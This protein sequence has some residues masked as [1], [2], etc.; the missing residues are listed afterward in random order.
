MSLPNRLTELWTL[1]EAIARETGGEPSGVFDVCGLLLERRPRVWDYFCSPQNAVTFASTGGDGV[2]FGLMQL[3][4]LAPDKLPVVM[5]V[6]MSDAHNIVVAESFE[7]FLGL[8]YRLGWFFLEQL[9]YDP[10]GT[11]T[12]F[13]GADPDSEECEALLERIRLSLGL[14]HVPLTAERIQHLQARY[15]PLLEVPDPR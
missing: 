6:P 15:A 12:Y 5:T 8:G 1:A 14:W 2:H 3:P 4:E 10:A 7:E 11:V 9:A 13:A